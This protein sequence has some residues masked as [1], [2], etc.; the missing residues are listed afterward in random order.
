MEVPIGRLAFGLVIRG[1]VGGAC[2]L[3][4]RQAGQL[5]VTHVVTDVAGA[6]SI[7]QKTRLVRSKL[8]LVLIGVSIH[9]AAVL[10][11]SLQVEET[12][13]LFLGGC[14]LQTFNYYIID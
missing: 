5:I 10:V 11:S 6:R 7:L 14:A 2:K 3:A 13:L 1:I 4:A 9:K 12:L 8:D